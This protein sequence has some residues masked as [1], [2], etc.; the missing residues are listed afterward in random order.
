M[1]QT[2]WFILKLDN[3][4]LTGKQYNARR[5]APRTADDA[6]RTTCQNVRRDVPRLEYDRTGCRRIADFNLVLW[7]KQRASVG[8]SFRVWTGPG[9][10]PKPVV[11]EP[12]AVDSAIRRAIRFLTHAAPYKS[13][14]E[15]FSDICSLLQVYADLPEQLAR[16]TTYSVFTS[17]FPDRTAIPTCV[18]IVGPQSRQGL[19]VFRLLSCLFRRALPLGDVSV[20]GLCSFPAG[21]CP[22]LF[23]RQRELTI[24]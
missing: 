24:Q 7:N 13:T 22:A 3:S 21:L 16:L 12:A 8:S 20:A 6:T 15:L 19:Q 9:P 11:F 23:L 18:S 14:R 4:Y 17:W 10:E 5:L 1:S 2:H